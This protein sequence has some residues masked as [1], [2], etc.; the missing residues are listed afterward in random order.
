MKCR[1]KDSSAINIYGNSNTSK[2]LHSSAC[3]TGVMMSPSIFPFPAIRG[4]GRCFFCTEIAV[5]FSA[6]I[7]TV[8]SKLGVSS[9]FKI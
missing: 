4:D 3:E 1:Y 8:T 7:V 2:Q 9:D 6:R 5:A